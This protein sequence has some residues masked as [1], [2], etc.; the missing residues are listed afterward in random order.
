MPSSFQAA[1]YSATLQYLGAVKAAGSDDGDK[2]LAQLR[3]GKLNDMYVKDGW[4]RG[5][6]LMVHDMHLLRGQD[7]GAVHR[8]LGLLPA[9]GDDQG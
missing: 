3:K 8:A 5:D 7:A 9:G 2:V 1:D 4:V 6:G